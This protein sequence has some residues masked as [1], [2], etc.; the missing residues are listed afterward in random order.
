[1]KLTG[2]IKLI[3]ET[4]EVGNNFMIRSLVL[5]TDDQYPQTI[6]VEFIKDKTYLLD[7]YNVGDSISI[8][9]NIRGREWTS[10]TGEV[11]YFT[12]ISGWRIESNASIMQEAKEAVTTAQQ[13]PDRE[14]A[15]VADDL[16]F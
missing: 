12:S 14:A 6:Q 1:M 10:P 13:S 4:K 9:I 3:G 2:T 15:K 8:D 16:P 5:T 11:K 7:N